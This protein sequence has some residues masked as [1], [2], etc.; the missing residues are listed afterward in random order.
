MTK[1]KIFIM[2]SIDETSIAGYN[3]FK[4]RKELERGLVRQ[5]VRREDVWK[6]GLSRK[7]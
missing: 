4:K 5:G 2:G 1:G 7:D 3:E 6:Y